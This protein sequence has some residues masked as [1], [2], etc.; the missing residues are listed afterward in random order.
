MSPEH[1]GFSIRKLKNHCSGSD[2]S[3][4]TLN[5]NLLKTYLSQDSRHYARR[6]HDVLR[7]KNLQKVSHHNIKHKRGVIEQH[8]FTVANCSAVG[9]S[10]EE[11]IP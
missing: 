7:M 1:E 10:Q 11:I 5:S 9:Y 2:G 3:Q 4:G 6:Q 8:K